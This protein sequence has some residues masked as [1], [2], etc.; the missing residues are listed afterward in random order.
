MSAPRPILGVLS[1][2][3]EAYKLWH[4][5]Q[6]NIPTFERYS[7]GAKAD[8]IFVDVIESIVTAS[9]LPTEQKLPFVSKA[10]IK[11][12]TFKFFLTLL[13]D[14]GNFEIKKYI[15]VNT[16]LEEIGKMLG[17]WRNQVLR[18][19]SSADKTKKF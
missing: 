4:T 8:A 16:L 11:L 10:I 1:K 2:V 9:F 15:A 12:D 14:M 3:L 19:N 7:L 18:Q 13:W 6:R 17:G 5:Y